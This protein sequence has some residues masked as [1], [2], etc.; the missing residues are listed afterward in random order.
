MKKYILLLF[1][2]FSGTLHAQTKMLIVPNV[3]QKESN[4][5]SAAAAECVLKY[6]K[7]NT[8]QCEIMDRAR[9]LEPLVYGGTT[10]T[11]FCCFPVNPNYNPCNKGVNL[12]YFNEKVSVK[13]MLMYFG[14]IASEAL[15][16]AQNTW[17][18]HNELTQGRPIFVQWSI[19]NGT[20]HTVVICGIKNWDLIFYMNPDEGKIDSLSWYDFFANDHHSWSGTLQCTGCSQ[21][22]DLYPCHCFNGEFEPWLEET[23][24]DCGGPC[25]KCY[26]PPPPLPGCDNC[27]KDQNEEQIDCGGPNCAPCEDVLQVKTIT[28]TN[29]LI[30]PNNVNQ[31]RPEVM[32][33]K[34]ITAGGATTIASGKKTSFIT[35]EEGSIVLLPGFKAEHGSNFTTQRWEDLSGYSRDCGEI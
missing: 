33:F 6:N 34:K 3:A 12:G 18:I 16:C 9:L 24:L 17:Q 27:I 15:Q 10:N 13:N 23:G 14:N 19:W 30:M 28:S 26:V 31:L 20:A 25:P 11:E 35:E 7:K 29:Q 8:G 22:G 4:W 5:C 21:R 1:L 2:G 32:A